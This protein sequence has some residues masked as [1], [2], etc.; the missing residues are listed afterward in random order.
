[1]SETDPGDAIVDQPPQ[2]PR[3]SLINT[4]V[5][6][7]QNNN[8]QRTPLSQKQK[9]LRSKGLTEDE[10]QIACERAGVFSH[11]PNS[12][13]INMGISTPTTQYVVQQPLTTLQRIREILSSTALIAG[14][15]YAIYLFYK[16]YIEPMLFGRRRKKKT[17]DE[18][19][20]DLNKNVETNIKELNQELVKVK[21]EIARASRNDNILREI[22]SFKSDIEH[23]KGLLLSRKQFSSPVVPPSIPA[24]QLQSQHIPVDN[25]NDKN[26]DA[27]SGSGSSETEVVTKNSDS[28]LEM[29]SS[30]MDEDKHN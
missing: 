12:T 27:N 3:E 8:V 21:E 28:S 5:Q 9:F 22:N 17:V 25:E 14:F 6:F 1:M 16:N 30:M 26:D 2:P 20:N 4:A 23:I 10:I 29:I 18:S 19:I 7:L 13:V 11:D 15:T 24:W